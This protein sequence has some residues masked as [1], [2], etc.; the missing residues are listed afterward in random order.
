VDG[1][2]WTVSRGTFATVQGDAG[3]FGPRLKG[4]SRD[5]DKSWWPGALDAA[6]NQ[7]LKGVGGELIDQSLPGTLQKTQLVQ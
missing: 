1:H 5:L 7:R 6:S 2:D 4:P 3:L